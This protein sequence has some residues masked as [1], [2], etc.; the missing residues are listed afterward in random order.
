MDE[1]R[2]ARRTRIQ[3]RS[4]DPMVPSLARVQRVRRELADTFTLELAPG[5]GDQGFTFAP[6]QFNM[7]YEFGVGEAAISISGDPADRSRIVHTIRAVGSVTKALSKLRRGSEVGVRGPFGSAW[8]ME[9]AEGSDIVFV[10]GGI[11][12]APLR[13]AIHRVLARR[14]EYGRV[15]ILYG[16]RTPRDLLYRRELESWRGRF[17]IFVDATVDRGT[18]DWGGNVGVV[19]NLV[20]R[21]S[22][23]PEH[24]VA[25]V[26]GPEVMMRFTVSALN[27]SGVGSEQIYLSMER[28]MKCGLG[29][30]GHCQLGPGFVCK[31]GPVYRF[32]QIEHLFSIR[33]L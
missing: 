27:V 12:L 15:V 9:A 16:A 24:T 18:T 6:G 7:L 4:V 23:D 3:A 31:D 21:A 28:S 11:G 13:P 22:F 19:T 30:C 20:S 26:C 29:F 2:A 14:R 17:D 8:P 25:M 1:R 10:A 5:P 32:N 33:E